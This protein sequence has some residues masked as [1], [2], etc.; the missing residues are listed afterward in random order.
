MSKKKKR[1]KNKIKVIKQSNDLSD[2]L[3]TVPQ[4]ILG[5]IRSRISLYQTEKNWVHHRYMADFL[6]QSVRV[7]YPDVAKLLNDGIV[8]VASY[9][10][11]RMGYDVCDNINVCQD[12]CKDVYNSSCSNYIQ[13]RKK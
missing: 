4:E 10:N 6:I 12:K 2:L 9:T 1:N 3:I 8:R 11:R 13:R 5:E 7:D